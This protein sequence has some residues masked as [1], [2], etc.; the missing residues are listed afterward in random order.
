M[1]LAD[2][3]LTEARFEPRFA[4]VELAGLAADSRKVKPG[5]LFVA[6]PGTKTD[7]TR[8]IGAAIAAGAAAI[9]AE[10]R[11]QGLAESFP[12]VEVR[13]ARRALA[14]CAAAFFP[15]QPKIVVAV[16]GT[17]GKTSVVAFLRQIWLMLGHRAASL[18]TIGLVHPG[19]HARG[20]LTTPD[21]IELH[22]ILD[23]LAGEGVTH[24]ALE[25]SSHGLDQ[26]RLDGV[27][28]AAGGF[29]NLSRDHLDYHAS[30][31]AYLAA[32]L[33]LFETL[34]VA[35]GSAVV[36]IDDAY[37]ARVVETAQT[38]GLRVMTVGIRGKDIS[39]KEVALDGFGQRIVLGHGGQDY[40]VRLPLV[41]AFQAQNALLAAGLAIATG[42]I[43][44]QVFAALAA[45]Q[46]AVGRLERVGERNGAPIFIDYAHKPDALRKALEAL[47][48]YAKGRLIVVFGAGGDRDAGKR[49]IMGRIAREN[50][51]RVI[52]TDDNPRSE[53]AATIRAAILAG[54]PDAIEIGDRGEAIRAAIR[55]LA[56]GD[57]LLIAGKGHETG[58]IVGDRVVPFSDHEA[59]AAA[60]KETTA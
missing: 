53:N 60:L 38:R 35:G 50:A 51:D 18:G 12:F 3:A 36:A 31:E 45:L 24:L 23:R 57:V 43:P 2:L 46:G 25:A 58:Q 32:K 9:A 47:R 14:L 20:S 6:V 48:P 28:V 13:D 44:G 26:K 40:R 56:P 7:G 22:R 33:R 29:T 4:C 5:E 37:G 19:G 27:R 52:V 59:V 15:R 10:R 54:A 39:L 11:P 16:T 34:V 30:L 55:M 42:G 1:K 49:P 8:F 41:G 17:S 21:P